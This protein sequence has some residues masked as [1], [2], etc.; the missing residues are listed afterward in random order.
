MRSPAAAIKDIAQ[1]VERDPLLCAQLLRIA[2]AAAH[3]QGAVASA[4][5]ALDRLGPQRVRPLVIAWSTRRLFVSHDAHIRSAMAGIWERSLMIGLLARDL[6]A[7]SGSAAPETAFLAG[8][9]QDIGRPVV[10]SFLLE[11]EKHAE[12]RKQRT[13]SPATFRTLV[14]QLATSV[15]I[16]LVDRWQLEPDF[17]SA[18]KSPGDFD[19]GNRASVP[20]FVRFAAAVVTTIDPPPRPESLDEARALVMVGRSLLDL[21]DEIVGR[22]TKDLKERAR[23]LMQ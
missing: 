21:D 19:A 15:G 11:L 20:N 13:L 6:T 14:D 4:E 8:L 10:A 12:S 7:L 18:V 1:A 9:L 2:A 17:A 16:A 3:G 5:A 22:V 23:K